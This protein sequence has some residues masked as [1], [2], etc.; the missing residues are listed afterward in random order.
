MHRRRAFWHWNVACGIS[1]DSIGTAG[2]DDLVEYYD[3]LC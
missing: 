1:E 3:G 2:Y